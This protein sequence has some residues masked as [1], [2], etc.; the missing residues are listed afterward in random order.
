MAA[1]LPLIGGVGRSPIHCRQGVIDTRAHDL[2]G[3]ALLVGITAKH[4]AIALRRS[5]VMLLKAFVWIGSR[6]NVFLRL[7]LP[8]ISAT[9]TGVG[10]DYKSD[11]DQHIFVYFSYPKFLSISILFLGFM[12]LTELWPSNYMYST[13]TSQ[14]LNDKS[15]II[16]H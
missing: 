5:Y 2:L 14:Q 7:C 9:C 13:Q 1:E 4:E 11:Y 8:L 6:N 12:I 15:K 3:A 10:S 16:E